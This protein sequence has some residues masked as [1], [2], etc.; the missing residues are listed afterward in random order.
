[1][2]VR[3]STR[4]R[5][6][7]QVTTKEPGVWTAED[8]ALV[9]IDYRN[10]RTAGARRCGAGHGARGRHRTLARPG[11]ATGLAGPASDVIYWYFS[12]VPKHT[13]RVGVAEAERAC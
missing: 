2:P 13:D 11:I 3:R 9:L 7:K 5:T 10:H 6:R 12:E 4:D 1:V 8:C